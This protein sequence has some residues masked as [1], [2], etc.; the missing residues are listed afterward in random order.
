MPASVVPVSVFLLLV[1]FILIKKQ[2][3]FAQIVT[4]PKTIKLQNFT[5]PPTRTPT[6]TAQ[7]SP[8]IAPPAS[9]S[10]PIPPVTSGPT[11]QPQPTD[12]PSSGEK[13]AEVMDLVNKIRQICPGGI[14]SISTLSCVNNLILPNNLS[15]LVQSELKFSTIHNTYLQCVG[16]VRAATARMYGYP[17]NNGGNAID[18]ATRLPT[19]YRFI[20]GKLG[21]RIRTNDLAIWNYDTYG[22]IAYVVEV[23]SPSVFKVAEANLGTRGEVRLS[24]TTI[25]SPNLIGWIRKN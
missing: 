12:V 8:T 22:H 4:S 19:G 7:P 2:I 11:N 21:A 25:D 16:F 5:P 15:I 23:F 9:N 13:A 1:N 20:D 17:V 18:F 6:M 24:I 14:I 3:V 10:S